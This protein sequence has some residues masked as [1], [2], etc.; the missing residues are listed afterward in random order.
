MRHFRVGLTLLIG[1]LLAG[2][3]SGEGSDTSQ[4]TNTNMGSEEAETETAQPKVEAT[5]KDPENNSIGTVSFF[6]NGEQIQIEAQL[7]G[8]EPGHHGFHIH[9]NGVCEADAT[10]GPFTTAGGHFNPDGKN[11]PEHAG[12]MPSLYVNDDG[13]AEYSAVFDRVTMDQ[14]TGGKLA[15]VIHAGADNF[16]NIPDRYQAKGNPGPDEETVKAGDA[17][18][19]E[20]CGVITGTEK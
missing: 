2:C 12:D 15:V 6:E 14:L 20:A 5:L 13:S 7:E 16:G 3:N 8:L 17:G 9:E 18:D 19:R 4:E 10:D 11:H 1:L